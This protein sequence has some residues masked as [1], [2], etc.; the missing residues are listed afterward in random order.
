VTANFLHGSW[1]HLIRNMLALLFLGYLI[2]A[3]YGRARLLVIYVLSCVAGTLASYLFTPNVSLG[4]STGIMGLMGALLL[5]NLKYRRYLPQR[6]NTV[7]PALI[8]FVMLELWWDVAAGGGVD[9]AGHLGGLLGG[10]V[11]AGLLESKIA[12]PLQGERDWLPLPTA[13]ATVGA[14]LAYGFAGMLLALPGNLD[15][16]RSSQ[17]PTTGEQIA[18]LEHALSRRPYFMEAQLGLADLLVDVQRDEDASRRYHE[19]E[20]RYPNS[21][22]VRKHLAHVHDTYVARADT[23]LD[24]KQWDVAAALATRAAEFA[25]TGEERAQSYLKRGDA[26]FGQEKWEQSLLDYKLAIE[27]ASERNTLATAHN[28]YAWTLADKLNRDL[29]AAESHAKTAVNLAPDNFAIMDTLAWVYYRQGRYREAM[30][31]QLQAVK[32][33]ERLMGFFDLEGELYY[34]LGAIYEKLGNVE[35]ARAQY[36]RALGARRNRYPEAAAALQRLEATSKH[37]PDLPPPTADPARQRGI[38]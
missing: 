32:T 34:H 4:A 38:L 30:S 35:D 12:G 17:A 6:V 9:V 7:Y 13:L 16:I 21:A 1:S 15:L 37:G 5:H 11:L 28:R 22:L 14:L 33:G 27:H 20:R 25:A 3:F 8:L 26:A 19:V 23:A 2:E 10:A 29:A 24:A 36:T 31:Q 18:R